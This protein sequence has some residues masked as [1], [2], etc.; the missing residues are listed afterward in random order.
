MGKRTGNSLWG[1]LQAPSSL[2]WGS[3]TSWVLP[4]PSL[5]LLQSPCLGG[6]PLPLAWRRRGKRVHSHGREAAA[7]RAD[8]PD[9]SQAWNVLRGSG[10][11]PLFSWGSWREDPG[12]GGQGSKGKA[13][14]QEAELRRFSSL[15]AGLKGRSWEVPGGRERTCF[16]PS[17]LA[18]LAWSLGQT[19]D[20]HSL[21]G[22]PFL[23]NCLRRGRCPAPIPSWVQ[24]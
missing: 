16:P 17:S 24:E 15:V 21:Q 1:V 20:P 5:L 18:S 7:A 6:A 10:D 11:S 13:E 12:A 23:E 9:D 22:T 19:D 3:P 4:K 2:H 14:G 8:I